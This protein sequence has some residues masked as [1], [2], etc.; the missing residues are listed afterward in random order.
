MFFSFSSIL[1]LFT[2]EAL[3]RVDVLSRTDE[4]RFPAKKKKEEKKNSPFVFLKSIESHRDAV[5]IVKVYHVVCSR[6]SVA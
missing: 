1:L 5:R 2:L 3:G 4:I 6:W